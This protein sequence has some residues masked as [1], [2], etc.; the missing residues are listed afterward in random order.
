MSSSLIILTQGCPSGTLPRQAIE[1]FVHSFGV[2]LFAVVSGAVSVLEM[3]DLKYRRTLHCIMLYF[4]FQSVYS[5]IDVIML[6]VHP[7]PKF[8]TIG[9]LEIKSI[10]TFQDWAAV[11]AGHAFYHLWYIKALFF[12]RLCAPCVMQVFEI[13]TY[14]RAGTC[15]L[16][17][18][19]C[20]SMVLSVQ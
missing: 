3:D 4:L 13:I 15:D 12:W 14:V 17:H 8:P 9:N 5:I 11:V 7:H 16:N 19:T 2:P 6:K 10:N 20:S 18:A 1:I